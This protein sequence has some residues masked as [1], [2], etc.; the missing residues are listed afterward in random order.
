MP[1]I[2][3]NQRT[4]YTLRA[5]GP[6]KWTRQW[7][8]A[9]VITIGFSSRRSESKVSNPARWNSNCVQQSRP[10]VGAT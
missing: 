5:R 1:R 6:L 8:A 9:G 10:V 7:C 3:G 2:A 4:S